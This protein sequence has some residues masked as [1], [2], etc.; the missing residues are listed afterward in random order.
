[1]SAGLHATARTSSDLDVDSRNFSHGFSPNRFRDHRRTVLHLRLTFLMFGKL[2]LKWHMQA[3]RVLLVL[4]K[5][6]RDL[7]P[8]RAESRPQAAARS[9][10]RPTG[11]AICQPRETAQ[12]SFGHGSHKVL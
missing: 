8:R 6:I 9:L 12:R 5:S 3:V 4:A 2:S 7:T 11:A 1:M 10:T